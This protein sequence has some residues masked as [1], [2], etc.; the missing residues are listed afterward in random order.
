MGG[1]GSWLCN[2]KNF[3]NEGDRRFGIKKDR[4]GTSKNCRRRQDIGGRPPEKEE[5]EC[6]GGNKDRRKTRGKLATMW[7]NNGKRSSIWMTQFIE[8]WKGFWSWMYEDSFWNGGQFPKTRDAKL[9]SGEK[10]VGPDFLEKMICSVCQASRRRSLQKCWGAEW[11]MVAVSL[12][13]HVFL[14]RKM[15]QVRDRLRSCQRWYVGGK[16]WLEV[17]SGSRNIACSGTP[18]MVARRS[19]AHSVGSTD[20]NGKIQEKA[21]RRSCGCGWVLDWANT[22][23]RVSLLVVWAWATHFSFPMKILRVLCGYWAPEA[24]ATRRMCAVIT[25]ILPRSVLPDALG[26]W[27]SCKKK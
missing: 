21:N 20:G 14:Y 19:P 13:D 22:F 8:E 6:E 15:L 25:A 16:F 5:E 11:Q 4:N 27:K 1:E 12:C 3:R 9:E 7:K 24:C 18:R 23:E 26:W 2:R 17:Q 10:I